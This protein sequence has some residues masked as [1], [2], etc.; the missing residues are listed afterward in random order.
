MRVAFLANSFHLKMT[1]S[2]DFFIRLLNKA[3][4][5]VHV[6]PFSEA[7]T[8]I[9]RSNWDMIIVWMEL[10]TPEELE[11]FGVRQVVL[12]PMSDYCPHERDYW[13]RYKQFKVFC[14][15]TTLLC[16]LRSWGINAFGLHY[17]PPVRTDLQVDDKSGLRG[18]FWPRVEH[19]GW[20]TIK[21]LIGDTGFESF[22]LHRAKELNPDLTDLPDK[23]DTER[24]SI[25]TSS[26]FKS[27]TDYV[28]TVR[29]ANVF[30]AS[31]RTEGIGMSYIEALSWGLCV[32]S[33]NAPTMSEYIVHGVNGLL[34]DPENPTPLDLSD[35]RALGKAAR[36]SCVLGRSE[37]ERAFND[38]RSFLE[39]PGGYYALPKHPL[40]R[41][42]RRSYVALRALYRA[43]KS[44]IRSIM[45]FLR[46]ES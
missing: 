44:C 33:P 17:Y 15:S 7:W 36:E 45:H 19:L 3:F 31:R 4:D 8:V 11:A 16:E 12:V 14:L 37:W 30:F 9:P 10:V 18:F 22:H 24:F 39:A 5:D 21:R 28:E 32:V 34:Y 29:K 27:H 2:S 23:E 26:W 42:K 1:K 40:I 46:P 25:Q 38:I 41:V 20:S 13:V 43:W 35:Y 6:I